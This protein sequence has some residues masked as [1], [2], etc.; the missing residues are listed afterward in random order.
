MLPRWIQLPSDLKNGRFARTSSPSPLAPA[1]WLKRRNGVAEP[2]TSPLSSRVRLEQPYAY[3]RASPPPLLPSRQDFVD[4][5]SRLFSNKINQPLADNASE[6]RHPQYSPA[7]HSHRLHC[8][9]KCQL[10]RLLAWSI[11]VNWLAG[12]HHAQFDRD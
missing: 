4:L 11:S 10:N 8:S 6:R 3:G 9:A 1:R 7:F 2:A 12:N 5:M